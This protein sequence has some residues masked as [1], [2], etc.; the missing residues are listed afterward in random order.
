MTLASYSVIQIVAIRRCI[1]VDEAIHLDQAGNGGVI[2]VRGIVVFFDCLLL[3]YFGVR[4]SF[5]CIVVAAT[6]VVVLT[7]ASP[8]EIPLL[9]QICRPVDFFCVTFGHLRHPLVLHLLPQQ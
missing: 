2:L 3:L 4:H 1:H 7:A 6:A 9:N 5:L 8:L